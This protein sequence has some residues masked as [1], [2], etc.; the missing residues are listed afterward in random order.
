VH[1]RGHG[2]QKTYVC[3]TSLLPVLPSRA[4]SKRLLGPRDARGGRD[5][6][7]EAERG[8]DDEDACAES[9]KLDFLG[10][11]NNG[12]TDGKKKTDK[13]ICF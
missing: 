7:Q 4:G 13:G 2:G 1:A 11:A 5:R 8:D 12:A 9:H 3:T 6:A 10:Q